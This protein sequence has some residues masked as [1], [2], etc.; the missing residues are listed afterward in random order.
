MRGMQLA[1]AHEGWMTEV[2]EVD[3]VANQTVYNIPEGTGRVKR[4]LLA[5]TS[6]TRTVYQPL[7][8]DERW[9]KST[10]SDTAN[11]VLGPL[12]LPTYRLL[13]NDLYLEPAP[14]TAR[15]N[16]LRLEHE[17]L[18]DRLVND[19]D[20]LDLRWPDV[21]E[22]LLVYDIWDLAVGVEDAQGNVD[23]RV[24]GRLRK[25]HQK[26]EGLFA[27]FTEERSFGRTFSQPF[28]LGD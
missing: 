28:S 19:G 27:L 1:E 22:S 9:D 23:E 10:V 8:R 2:S 16:G 7:T 26:Y 5:F 18:P 20:K 15:T 13:N 25:V 12:D 14:G 17:S 11:A 3:T 21:M 24:M 6:G 4:V